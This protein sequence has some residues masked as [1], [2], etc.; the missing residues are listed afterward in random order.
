M[1]QKKL[2]LNH[3]EYQH[4]TFAT[5]SYQQF[6]PP[7]TNISSANLHKLFDSLVAHLDNQ[8][9]TREEKDHMSTVHLMAGAP[10]TCSSIKERVSQVGAKVK[11]KWTLEEIGDSGWR[12]G[13]YLAY[14]QA[15]DD[16]TDTLTVQYPSEPEC[17][18]TFELT[19]FIYKYKIQLV[20]AVM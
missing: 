1:S 20:K 2:Q 19:P 8:R 18:Y 16:E 3:H 4:R 13:W 9:G 17:I 5:T 14:V 11:I 10:P 7:P 12:P 6:V 15:Y